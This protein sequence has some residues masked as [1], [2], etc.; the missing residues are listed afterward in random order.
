MDVRRGEHVEPNPVEERFH[1]RLGRPWRDDLLVASRRAVA[2]EDVAHTLHLDGHGA[3][4][5]SDLRQA[6]RRVPFEH[7]APDLASLVV[8][9]SRQ[10]EKRRLRV[11][12]DEDGIPDVVRER[13]RLLRLR[14]PG[15]VAVHDD[16][17]RWV[18]PQLVD[19]GRQRRGVPVHVRDHGKA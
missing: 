1:P 5:S 4:E 3:R 15:E 18:A 6:L 17:L 14:A 8:P 19:H 7:P 16:E 13:Q 2:A 12:A 10:A 9:R 11:P